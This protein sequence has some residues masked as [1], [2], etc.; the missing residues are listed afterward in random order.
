LGVITQ[1][2]ACKKLGISESQ[3]RRKIKDYGIEHKR[4]AMQQNP[5][6]RKG[7]RQDWRTKLMRLATNSV[8]FTTQEAMQALGDVSRKTSVSHLKTLTQ[9]GV[10]LHVGR[11]KYCRASK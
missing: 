8:E 5:S 4:P 6:D 3:L 9:V 10:L 1:A 2:E 11:G 7:I